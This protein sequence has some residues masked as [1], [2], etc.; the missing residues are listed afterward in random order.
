MTAAKVES[1]LSDLL[2]S[3]TCV[4]SRHAHKHTQANTPINYLGSVPLSASLTLR[5]WGPNKPEPGREREKERKRECKK[6]NRPKQA[7]SK[8]FTC[9]VTVTR[10]AVEHDL[11]TDHSIVKLCPTMSLFFIYCSLLFSSTFL[12][13]I[14][15]ERCYVLHCVLF[16]MLF[17]E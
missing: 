17:R 10:K 3:L 6:Q 2:P 15:Q 8:H 5:Q 9:L 13:V 7:L 14:T 11:Q 16:F 4:E 12:S 1:H